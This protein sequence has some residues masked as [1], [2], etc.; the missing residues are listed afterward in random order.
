MATE[1]RNKLSALSQIRPD[2]HVALVRRLR[3]HAKKIKNRACEPMAQDMLEAALTIE[4]EVLYRDA[5]ANRLAGD[6]TVGEATAFKQMSERFT[7]EDA[8]R[9]SNGD[10]ERD[11]L[12]DGIEKLRSAL[13]DAGFAP[14]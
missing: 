14:H 5:F 9:L 4:R 6:L 11:A 8:V 12:L 13:A 1:S 3:D 7:F 10:A 2:K